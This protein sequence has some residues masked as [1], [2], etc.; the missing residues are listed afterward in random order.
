MK[1]EADGDWAT[2]LEVMTEVKVCHVMS[3]W[4]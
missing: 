3:V 2:T 1:A 4:C